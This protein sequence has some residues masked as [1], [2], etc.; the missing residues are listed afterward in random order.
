VVGGDDAYG[1][2]GRAEAEAW[3]R[4]RARLD[5]PVDPAE[6]E[7]L[8]PQRPGVIIHFSPNTIQ[9]A[10]AILQPP[11]FDAAGD[12]A[13][14]YGS[15]GAGMAHEIGHTFDELGSLYDAEGRL[16]RWWTDEDMARFRAAS[17][18]MEEQLAAYCLRPDLCVDAALVL[19]ETNADLVGLQ[20]AWDAYQRSL[21]GRPDEVIDGLT[22]DQRF[23]LAFARR[24]RRL[25][26]EAGL[27]QQFA[28]DNHAPGPYRA[29]TVRNLEAWARAFS[30]P[31]DAPLFLAPEDR[32]RVW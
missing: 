11:Y 9:F 2:G 20:V 27:R 31:E 4:E 24:W 10:A 17:A 21:G 16:V 19:R 18:P 15:A 28:T 6:W 7:S 14:N 30:I 29:A 1:N 23:F 22:G 25:Q 3:R 26:D 13:S 8:P 12:A 5:R 32:V